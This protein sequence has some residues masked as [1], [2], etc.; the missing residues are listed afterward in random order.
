[1][2]SQLKSLF[3]HTTHKVHS[4]KTLELLDPTVQQLLDA[5]LGRLNSRLRLRVELVR[6][7]RL[8]RPLVITIGGI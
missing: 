6:L 3:Q 7:V 1:M 8:E 5:L 2:H 4:L